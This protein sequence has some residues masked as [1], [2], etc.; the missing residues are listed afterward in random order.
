MNAFDDRRRNRL[1]RRAKIDDVVESRKAE[2]PRIFWESKFGIIYILC[3]NSIYF[4]ILIV[5]CVYIPH[6]EVDQL[7]TLRIHKPTYCLRHYSE[8][9]DEDVGDD[10]RDELRPSA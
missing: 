3:N 9:Y 5:L 7:N 1:R 2:L 4:M 8:D 10:D 6:P